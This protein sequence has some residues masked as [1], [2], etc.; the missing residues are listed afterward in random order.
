MALYEEARRPKTTLP[1]HLR[2]PGPQPGSFVRYES[3]G[4][5]HRGGSAGLFFLF[6]LDGEADEELWH[7]A[8]L[9]LDSAVYER[10]AEALGAEGLE[11]AL[12]AVGIC[13]ACW[14]LM[15]EPRTSL[16]VGAAAPGAVSAE[17][18]AFWN[19]TLRGTL[20]EFQYLNR[21]PFHPVVVLAEADD[22]S[23]E[24]E[25]YA[26]L[27]WGLTRLCCLPHPQLLPPSHRAAFGNHQL[28]WGIHL[29]SSPSVA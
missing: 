7:R 15:E 12:L 17:Q 18:L 14:L 8:E 26:L 2:K 27:L 5:A 21:L 19:Q 24:A 28:L 16:Q 20:A 9:E 3:H 1:P 4:V 29:G 6:S 25:T 23:G 11:Q 10:A 22:A 13:A